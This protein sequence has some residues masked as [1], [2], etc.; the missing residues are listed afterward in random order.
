M[1]IHAKHRKFFY[2]F[3]IMLQV[4]KS[5]WVI[6]PSGATVGAVILLFIVWEV[7]SPHIMVVRFV[8]TEVLKFIPGVVY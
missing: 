3:I 7:I 6:A 1:T 5:S 8:T 4:V 2:G